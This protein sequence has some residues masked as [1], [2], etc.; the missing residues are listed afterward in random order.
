[1]TAEA[2]IEPFRIAISRAFPGLSGSTFRLLPE[3]WHST[4]VDVDDRLIVKFPRHEEAAKALVRE[5]GLLALVRPAVS[6]PVSDLTLHPG[7]PLFSRH[8]KLKGEHLS[9]AQYD[10]LPEQARRQLAGRMALFY[11]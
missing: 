1:M 4:A 5:A 9:T 7:P 11:A 6:M 10:R 3:G 8:G 2:G